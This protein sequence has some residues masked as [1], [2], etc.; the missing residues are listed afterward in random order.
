MSYNDYGVIMVLEEEIEQG[1]RQLEFK[2]NPFTD[3]MEK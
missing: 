1:M 2:S 3:H